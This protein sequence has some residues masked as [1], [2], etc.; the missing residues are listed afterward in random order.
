KL[1]QGREAA[2]AVLADNPEL[3]DELEARI[4]EALCADGVSAPKKEK[5][6]PINDA[7]EA[8]SEA[9]LE[10]DFDDLADDFALSE[11]I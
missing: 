4:M 8:D 7:E 6:K 3:A 1:A 9:P 2:K 5:E 10:D 11:D